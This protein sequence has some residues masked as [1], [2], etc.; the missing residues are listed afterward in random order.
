MRRVA[1]LLLALALA[2][3]GG[4]TTPRPVESGDA[5][6][7][8]LRR[9]AQLAYGQGRYDQA[10]TLY[11]SAID[12]AGARDDGTALADLGYDLAVSE[13]RRGKPE[14]AL[15]AARAARAELAR[16]G[17]G[18]FAELILVEAA[19]AYRTGDVRTAAGL[20]DA[21]LAAPDATPELR[22]RARFLG[23]EIAAD[24]RDRAALAAALA[25]LDGVAAMETAGERAELAGRLALLDGDAALA[26]DR[27]LAAA[28][29]R[30][31][32]LDYAGMAR[33]LARAAATREAAG[34]GAEAA[35]LYLR[36]G[37]SVALAGFGGDARPWLSRAAELARAAGRPEL[38]READAL[39]Q[40]AD[41]AR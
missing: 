41:A 24:A 8:R 7:A 27:F 22:A 37:R 12:R 33:S 2:A 6:L 19:A 40:R 32:T 21:A 35:D 20:V 38:A 13:L 3:C 34:R 18:P 28:D 15:A 23:G 4:A 5:E 11:R 9:S 10:A 31:D 26:G 25:A 16:R 39:L 17:R 14:E 29:S 1:P 30:R 36:A